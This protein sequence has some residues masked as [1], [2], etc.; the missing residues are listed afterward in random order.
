VPYISDPAF[1]GYGTPQQ[2]LVI[3]I[4]TKE[5]NNT[6]SLPHNKYSGHCMGTTLKNMNVCYPD[7]HVEKHNPAQIQCVQTSPNA[8]PADWFY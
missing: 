8:Q 5:A 4:N 6:G 7:G 3:D 1:S 2:P